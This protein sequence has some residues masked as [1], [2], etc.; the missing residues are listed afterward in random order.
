M[1]ILQINT[2]N[3]GSTGKIAINIKNTAEKQGNKIYI[4]YAKSRSNLKNKMEE[5]I[6][7]GS[8]FSR[9]LH[10]ILSAFSG[11][12]GCFSVLATMKFLCRVKKINPDVIH[13]HNLHNC[14][15][16][17]PTLF[18]YIKRHNI[19]TVWTLHDCWSFTG[20]CPYFQSTGCDKWKTSCENCCYPKNA[21]PASL[22]FDNTKQMYKFKKSWFTGVKDMT[23][24]TPSQW[25]ADLVKQSFLKD[26]PVKVINNG[27]DLEIFKPRESEFRKK[28]SFQ[29]KFL[30][31][32]VAAGWEKRKGLDV[33]LELSKRFDDR[34]KIVLVGTNDSVDKQLP[35]NIISIHRTQNQTELAEIYSVVDLFVNPTREE[36]YPTVNMESVACGT[37]VVTFDTGGSPEMLDKTCGT[38][39][40]RDDID[41]LYNEIIRIS[42]QK[43]FTRDACIQKAKSY[44]M[45]DKF[46][47]YIELYEQSTAN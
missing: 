13:L 33:F 7:V 27:I 21:Y 38:V 19:R 34:F 40:P 24:V 14:Y 11:F 45:N 15:I 9:N 18:N 22:F 1:K 28:Y 17:L 16:N 30:L 37:P 31:L 20:R 41:A 5:D 42:E 44:D 12:N 39:V 29:D 3:F 2:C 25:L 46:K 32:G 10:L 47:E 36:N 23:I 6:T 4:A 35:E 43:P 8:I 26:Y